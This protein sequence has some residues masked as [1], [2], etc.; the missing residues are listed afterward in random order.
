[1]SSSPWLE[2]NGTGSLRRGSSLVHNSLHERLTKFIIDFYWNHSVIKFTFCL[3]KFPKLSVSI[4]MKRHFDSFAIIMR[5]LIIGAVCG[6]GGGDEV[7]PNQH[8]LGMKATKN[9]RGKSHLIQQVSS[10]VF[11][12]VKFLFLLIWATPGRLRAISWYL[13]DNFFWGLWCPV[14]NPAQPHSKQAYCLLYYCSGP[15]KILA[16]HVADPDSSPSTTYGPL[17]TNR[18]DPEHRAMNKPCIP[19]NVSPSQNQKGV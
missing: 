12:E 10:L 15:L 8:L 4:P 5:M 9:S 19:P 7:L 14:S 1:M 3:I 6:G 2:K 11:G 13:G 17:N 18:S 16:L